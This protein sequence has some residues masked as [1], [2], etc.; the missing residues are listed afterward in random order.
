LAV[1][2]PADLAEACALTEGTEL[3]VRHEAGV[4]VL[5]PDRRRRRRYALSR[6]VAGITRR[7]RPELVDWG[8]PRGREIW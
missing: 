6:L 8:H 3:E 2:I 4:L 5:V 7:N 1:R